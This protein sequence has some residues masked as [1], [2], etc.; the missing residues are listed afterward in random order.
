MS[1]ID[2]KKEMKDFYNSS[3]KE[4]K[5]VDL[6]KLNY[7]M[8]DGKGDPNTAQE[9]KDAIETLYPVAY[10]I[11]F[12]IKKGIEAIDYSVM[13][14]EGLWWVEDMS[15]FSTEKKNDW[16]WT[17]MIMQPEFVTRK[18]YKSALEAVENKKNPAALDKIRFE[19]YAE[20]FSAQIMHI[21]PYAEEGPAIQKLHSFITGNN[22]DLRG[23]H[24]EIY[25]SDP[26]RA[27]PSKLKTIV[28][29]PA[30]KK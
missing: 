15:D 25:L 4:P 1:K 13:P 30:G 7:L 8:I 24:H 3:P 6:P 17:A 21:G 20:G 9:Y 5:F 2:H 29:Q 10:A 16:L 26:R 19:E 18:H 11:K 27:D 28:R 14:L 12:A 23:K 22:C